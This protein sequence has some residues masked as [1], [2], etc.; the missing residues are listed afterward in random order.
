METKQIEHIR[1]KCIEANPSIKD[2]VFGCD[3]SIYGKYFRIIRAYEDI[4]SYDLENN[5]R[6][7]IEML[8]K[9]IYIQILGREIRLTDVLLALSK[10]KNCD[11]LNI[12]VLGA[13]RE[14]V[15][16]FTPQSYSAFWNLKQDNLELQSKECIDFIF[17]LLK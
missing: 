17:N 16:G 12:D 15:P 8:T 14:K 10:V 2:L 11:G 4:K 5:T 3:I 13:I 6:Y 7:T 9:T 1:S